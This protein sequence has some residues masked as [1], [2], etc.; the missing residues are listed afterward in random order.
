[1]IADFATTTIAG[2]KVLLARNRGETLPEGCIVD[3]YGR[4]STNPEDYYDGGALVSFG[5]YKG[6]AIGLLVE[7]LG[8]ILGASDYFAET[9]RGGPMFRRGAS[10]RHAGMSILAIDPGT[11]GGDA[12]AAV[13]S[14]D[15]L[16]KVRAS[17]PAEGVEQVMAPGDP[18][19]K[20][21]LLREAQ[22]I[23]V[24]DEVWKGITDLLADPKRR[25]DVP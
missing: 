24:A 11:F 12:V 8:R 4:P 15:F 9:E 10:F 23:L 20:T 21:R 6:Y 19:R 13:R 18:E 14:G 16:N 17:R 7:F 3:R 25:P 2:G 1:M 22:G 5:G